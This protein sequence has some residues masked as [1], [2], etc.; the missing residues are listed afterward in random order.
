MSENTPEPQDLDQFDELDARTPDERDLEA[1]DADEVEQHEELRE[2]PPWG[3]GVP[4]L[5]ADPQDAA[6]Q[7]RVVEIDEDDYR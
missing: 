1:P 3:V 7:R 5:E 2:V 6:D 4:P